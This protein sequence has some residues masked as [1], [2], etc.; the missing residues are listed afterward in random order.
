MKSK[1]S[2]VHYSLLAALLVGVPCVADAA[3]RIDNHSRGYAAGNAQT[4]PSVRSQMT[5]GNSNAVMG[6]V[7]A[8]PADTVQNTAPAQTNNIATVPANENSLSATASHECPLI[9]PNGEIMWGT[10]TIGAGIGGADTCVAVVEL[11]GYQAAKDGSNLVLARANLALGDTFKCNISSFPEATMYIDAVESFYFPSDNP[12]SMDD[13][14][15]QMNREQK[16]NAGLK[17][18]AGAVIGGLGGNMAGDGNGDSL[19]GTDKGKIQGTVIGALSGAALMA[20]NAYAGKVAGDVILSTGVNAAAGGVVGNMVQT[21]DSVLR[22]ED[23]VIPDQDAENGER[24]TTCLWGALATTDN[25]L[26]SGETAYYRIDDTS[27]AT[28]VC[29]GT[30]DNTTCDQERLVNIRL[31]AYP[32]TDITKIKEEQFEKIYNTTLGLQYY[33]TTDPNGNVAFTQ[34]G[35]NSDNGI[36][37]KISSANRIKNEIPAMIELQDKAFGFSSEDWDEWKG[38]NGAGVKIYGRSTTGNAYELSGEN[39]ASIQNF[40]PMK[41]DADDGAVIDF[42]NKARLK[43]TLIGAGVGGALGGFAAY[44]GAQLDVQNRWTT[45]MREYEDSLSTVFC[46][47]GSRWL[48]RYNDSVFIP[49]S[50]A[51]VE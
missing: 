47:T 22:I 1:R 10:P 29:S 37:A 14:V 38:N 48:S 26:G 27:G 32:N 9:Y 6:T 15:A 28:Y 8:V 51:T 24:K 50:L 16:Q 5:P 20:G 40:Y 30:G 13:V 7:A 31:A 11:V 45:A 18:A 35:A 46:R 43:N 12:P 49:S 21:G 3:L 41:I 17:I 2:I 36:W 25:G 4:A 19:L 42:G 44:Q 33:M 39:V 23:C 34:S